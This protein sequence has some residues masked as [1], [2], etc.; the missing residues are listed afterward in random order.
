M[1]EAYY[2]LFRMEK[3]YPTLPTSND[4][5][6]DKLN[7][8]STHEAIDICI[9]HTLEYATETTT[10]PRGPPMPGYI[11]EM[12]VEKRKLRKRWQF[13]RCPTMKRQ[14]NR[15][16]EKIK[17]EVKAYTEYSLAWRKTAFVCRKIFILVMKDK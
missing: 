7:D 8:V 6:V 2:S 5:V 14:I 17:A 1:S 3:N 9:K 11:K 13:T 10:K 16:T 15:L 12:I 4:I